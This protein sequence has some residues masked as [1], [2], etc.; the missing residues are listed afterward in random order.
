MKFSCYITNKKTHT[1]IINVCIFLVIF[2][3]FFNTSL[4]IS[5][6]SNTVELFIYKILPSLFIYIFITEIILNFGIADSLAFGINNILSNSASCVIIGFLLGYPNS[7]KYILKLYNEHKITSSTAIK[8]S[9]FTSNANPAYIL[10][11][12]GIGMFNNIS[13]GLILLLSHIISAIIIGIIYNPTNSEIIIQ[14]TT[15]N[16][17]TFKKIYSSFEILS[18]S[19]FGT[20]KT[21]SLIF[22]YT[23]IFSL[24]PILITTNMHLS[25][26]VSSLI[27]GILEISNGINLIVNTNINM[28]HQIVLISFILSFSSLMVIMQ[29]YTFVKYTGVKFSALVKFKLVQGVLSSILTLSLLKFIDNSTINVFSNIELTKNY[30]LSSSLVHFIHILVT[31][32]VIF[33]CLSQKKSDKQIVA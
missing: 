5:S 19:I 22:S 28:H 30:I 17:N 7:A 25:Q 3:L 31:L 4:I 18:K 8:L 21:L 16:S 10:G 6:I 32:G 15:S 11:T 33:F 2:F 26:V 9:A 14:Q 23:I 13:I 20:L 27:T 1:L 12:I 29:I 24:I